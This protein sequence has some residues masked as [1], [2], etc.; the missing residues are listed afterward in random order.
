MK[1]KHG[2]EIQLGDILDSD[3]G[4]SVVVCEYEAGGWYGKLMPDS[5]S[6]PY[7]LNEGRGYTKR[8]P[9]APPDAAS[10][11]ARWG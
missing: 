9:D 5:S 7:A 6:C 8:R 1:D 3:D 11:K 4:Y 2:N 10:V